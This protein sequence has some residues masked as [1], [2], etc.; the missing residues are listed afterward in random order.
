MGGGRFA[1]RGWIM[2]AISFPIYRRPA[3]LIRWLV[4][5]GVMSGMV[6]GLYIVLA[7]FSASKECHGGAFSAAFSKGFDVRGCDL[8]VRRFGRDIGIRI[9]L[10]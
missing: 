8:V 3:D 1:E 4:R 7:Q 9:S 2:S 6:F 5:A 10:P